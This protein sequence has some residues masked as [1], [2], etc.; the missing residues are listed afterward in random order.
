VS[1]GSPLPT[2]SGIKEPRRTSGRPKHVV[3]SI[4]AARRGE[5]VRGRTDP[6]PGDVSK[7]RLQEALTDWTHD[8]H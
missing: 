8:W 2:A 7:G 3:F 1:T 5:W 4:T 6:A